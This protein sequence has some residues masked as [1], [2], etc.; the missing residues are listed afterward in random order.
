[1][2]VYCSMC[3]SL[4]PFIVLCLQ[5]KMSRQSFSV[6]GQTFSIS[7][8]LLDSGPNTRLSTIAT[9]GNELVELDRPRDSFGAI[10]N[11]YITGELHIPPNVC[12]GE[13]KK[14]MEYW[15][16]DVQSLSDCCF[17]R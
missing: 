12:P 14:E 17:F 1:M 5:K 7:R 15:K 6:G 8:E 9:K 11:L 4:Q 13:F 10:L 16:I 2:K 3:I